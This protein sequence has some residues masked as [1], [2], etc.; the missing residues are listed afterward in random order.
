M[1]DLYQGWATWDTW[2][3]Y[4]ALNNNDHIRN[5]L[6]KCDS[7]ESVKLLWQECW[8]G[9]N[10]VETEKVNWVELFTRGEVQ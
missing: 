1:Q 6:A 9:T 10:G 2:K 4:E 3:A 7:P 5:L 8:E